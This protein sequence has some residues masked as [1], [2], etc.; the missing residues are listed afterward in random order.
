MSIET[1]MHI[2][3]ITHPII[4]LPTLEHKEENP[5]KRTVDPTGVTSQAS[6]SSAQLVFSHTLY[7]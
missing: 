1:L 4:Q 6:V 3:Y 7:N 5:R 2:L